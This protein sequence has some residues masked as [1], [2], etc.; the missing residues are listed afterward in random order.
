MKA[1]S[2]SSSKRWGSI[3]PLVSGEPEMEL[4]ERDFTSSALLLNVLGEGTFSDLLVFIVRYGPDPAT[5]TAD[6]PWSLVTHWPA[7][8]PSTTSPFA[9]ATSSW[10]RR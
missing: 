2:S 1:E 9:A 7:S 3:R 6:L 5:T 4:D 10:R 8:S